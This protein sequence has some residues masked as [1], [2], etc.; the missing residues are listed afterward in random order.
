MFSKI[1]RASVTPWLTLCL[2]FCVTET[3]RGQVP[4]KREFRAAWVATVENLDWPSTRG[5][6]PDPQKAEL[7][8]LLDQLKATGISCVVFQVRPACDALYASPYE[9]W[10]YWLTGTQGA[11]PAVEFD[12][13]AFAV[14]EAHK[15]GMELHAWFNPYR[16]EKTI[17][18][19]TLADNHVVKQ[20]PDWILTFPST[21]LKI[22]DPGLPQVREFNA[23]IVAD[24]VRRYDVDGVHADDYFYPYDPTITTEDATTFQNHSRGFTNIGDWRRDNVNLQ[25]KMLMDSVNAIKPYV[26]FGMSPFGIWRPG[27]PPGITGLDAY[28]TLFADALAWLRD[29]SIDYLTP[30]LY[31]P[32]GGGQDY[33]KLMP[34]WADSTAAYGRH[35][36]PGMAPYRIG[37]WTAAEVPN[38]IKL[39]RGNPK[40]GGE[41]YFRARN[42][43]TDNLK[44]FQDSLKQ[45]YYKYPA[46]HPVMAW[47]DVVQPYPVRGIRY[48]AL[49]GNG[50]LAVQWDLPLQ[51]P[52]G[53]YASRYAVYRFDHYPSG[54]EF[55]D[56]RNMLSV[57]GNMYVVPPPASN[58]LLP[59][60]FVVR[61][62][63]RNYNEG[64]TSNVLIIGTPTIPTL[65]SPADLATNLSDSP[66]LLWNQVSGGAY[67]QVQV[68]T[69]AAFASG[70]ALDAAN[71]T[72]T[73]ATASG[74]TG[75]T[76]Y[77]WR[78]RASSAG[79]T[80]LWSGARSFSTGTPATATLVFP[81]NGTVNVPL[82]TP[83]RWN[84]ALA[85][86]AYQVQVSTNSAFSA[87]VVDSANVADT[88]MTI[89]GLQ[90]LRNHYW[91]VR[92]KNTYG[93]GAWSTFFG[94]RTVQVVAVD[95]ASEAPREFRLEQNFPNPFN[96]TTTIGFTV[97]QPGHVSIKIFDLLGREQ[98]SLVD[99]VLPAG[100]FTVTW[101]AAAAASGIY[102]YRM[103]AGEFVQTRRMVLMR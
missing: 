51:A 88:S 58:P 81:A 52:D 3:S 56:P 102:F 50:G 92:G 40:V 96:P 87:I 53:D 78:V 13:L 8:T 74:L 21:K 98:T 59:S 100:S 11:G 27:Y 93:V 29:R 44:G 72:D 62:L 37:S 12:P 86:T 82:S 25:M 9:P 57:E 32:I 55:D 76:T 36:Y 19:F 94:F 42:G 79:G 1:L 26:K 64:D 63:D 46:L 22:L 80:G 84:K 5:T 38:Q 39:N 71:L 77:Y 90:G 69:D 16:A 41:V 15:R 101:D 6:N 89:S 45:N 10:S 97:R 67:Y 66:R 24:I 33:S 20:H 70:I 18:Q 17:G 54:A 34:W 43:I 48:A 83:L 75:L 60:Y 65:V 73:S 103:V 30:Q 85:A 14:A 99:Q 7:V 23:K 91:R 49:P 47:K 2:C 4:P 95:D 31:W 28:N 61:S 68:A 35:L